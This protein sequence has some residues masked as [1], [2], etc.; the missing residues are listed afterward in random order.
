M[1]RFVTAVDMCEPQPRHVPEL[2]GLRGIAILLVMIFHFSGDITANSV[3]GRA[4]LK[5]CGVGWVGVD[6]FFVLSGYLITGILLE[7]KGAPRFFRNF[8]ARRTIRIFPLYYGVLLIIFIVLPWFGLF[9]PKI[10]QLRELA[11]AQAWFWLYGTNVLVALKG[12]S[13]T[14]SGT[15][16][17]THF[18]TLAVE[19][20][21]YL[22]WPAVVRWIESRKMIQIGFILVV[23]CAVARAVMSYGAEQPV[24]SYCL[25]PF[26]VDSLAMGAMLAAFIRSVRPTSIDIRR[27][28]AR[29]IAATT[30]V[31]LALFFW[32]RGLHPHD[33]LVQVIGYPLLGAIFSSLIML[34]SVAKRHSLLAIVLR[35]QMLTSLGKY[36]YGLYVFHVLLWQP[37][38][39]WLPAKQ[40]AQQLGSAAGGALLHIA[41]LSAASFVIAYIS[42]HCYEKHFLRLKRFFEYRSLPVRSAASGVVE[43]APAPAKKIRDIHDK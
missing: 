42:W 2:D 4:L 37:L 23:V 30:P 35:L 26:R 22:V 36:S 7:A 11:D 31:L 10:P 40:L 24:I 39:R 6:L 1:G 38:N 34:A 3:V 8:Y 19:E 13:A 28:A 27:L 29:T 18:W 25:T 41:L 16:I 20:H 33:P 14:A 43:S 15:V 21:F 12:I 9:V 17:L 5:L 32:R